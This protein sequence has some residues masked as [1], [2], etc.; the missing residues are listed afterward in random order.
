MSL[1]QMTLPKSATVHEIER[2]IVSIDPAT[3]EEVGRVAAANKTD[4]IAAVERARE[5]VALE[6]VGFDRAPLVVLRATTG[7]AVPAMNGNV[8]SLTVALNVFAC[9]TT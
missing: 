7:A 2:E 1:T 6:A 5:H 9:C 4:V 3:G 8:P